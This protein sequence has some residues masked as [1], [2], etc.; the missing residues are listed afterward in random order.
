[1]IMS[2]S[3]ACSSVSCR[4][5]NTFIGTCFSCHLKHHVARGRGYDGQPAGPQQGDILYHDLP[6]DMEI[7]ESSVPVTGVLDVPMISAMRLRLSAAS[8][9]SVSFPTLT[10]VALV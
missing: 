5:T 10:R 3:S 4:H 2:S 1:M 9:L 7:F 8:I 6:C